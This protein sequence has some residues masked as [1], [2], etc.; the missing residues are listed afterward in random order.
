MREHLS[1]A[2]APFQVVQG[3]RLPPHVDVLLNQVDEAIWFFSR[4]PR[5]RRLVL[6]M[7]AGRVKD[8]LGFEPDQL[9][10]DP[11]LLRTAIHPD[12]APRIAKEW[13]LLV[14]G[15]QVR[16]YEYRLRQAEAG[17]RWVEERVSPQFD[18][19][20]RLCGVLGV[21]RDITERKRVE[22][23]LRQSQEQMRHAQKMEAVGRLAGGIA[24]DFN[25]L[26]TVIAGHTDLLLEALPSDDERRQDAEAVAKAAGRATALVRQLL[27]FSRR[28]TLRPDVMELPALLAD[29][30]AMLT[31]LIGEDIKLSLAMEPGVG[32]VRADRTQIEQVVVNLVVNARDAMPAGG[33]VVIEVRNAAGRDEPALERMGAAPGEYVVLA[34]HDT[35][36]GIDADTASHLFEP[37]FTT[38]ADGKGTGLGLATVYGIVKQSEGHI[39]VRSE[40]GR[41]A[42]FSVYLPRALQ[43]P[44]RA[45]HQTGGP[46]TVPRRLPEETTILVAEDDDAVRG[47]VVTALRARG[48]VVIEASRAAEALEA[49][50]A[51]RGRIDAVLTDLV[52][53][54]GTGSE[55]ATALER[56][57]PDIAIGFMTGYTD[58]ETWRSAEATGYPVLAKPF[59]AERLY[60]M[61]D[62][63]VASSDQSR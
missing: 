3:G 16:W 14:R 1:P 35:G 37:F 25:N 58:A 54:G 24:H 9:K 43:A 62:S 50:A 33:S 21:T 48:H 63:L 52:M 34:V 30:Q 26:L 12:D 31:R 19:R 42:S 44:V 49:S 23:S 32:A 13:A 22:D 7:L 61:I 56:E 51:F 29:L 53:P 2:D 8:I 60:E 45:I 47:F 6:E 39:D 38:K 57:R 15:R 40:A 17:Y 4:P 59:T 55:L 36:T 10:A 5:A 11:G 20:N 18:V 41:G 28:Q 46:V 27:V